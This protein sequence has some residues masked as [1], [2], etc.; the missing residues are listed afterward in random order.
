VCLE[1]CRSPAE[2]LTR[3]WQ[4][5]HAGAFRRGV[6]HG[7]Y[8]LGCC[9]ALMALLFVGG[10]MNVC[11]IAGLA[12]VVLLEKLLPRGDRFALAF[13]LMFVAA[14]AWIAIRAV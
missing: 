1:H 9:W 5:G 2:F 7:A 14:G 10:I 8:C 3:H 4:K 11:W 6:E 12:I 13:G